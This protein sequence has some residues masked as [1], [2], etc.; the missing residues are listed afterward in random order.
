ME[1]RTYP[2][3][4]TVELGDFTEDD[5][6]RLA[7]QSKDERKMFSICDEAVVSIELKEGQA[8][9]T[10]FYEELR[11]LAYMDDRNSKEARSLIQNSYI[12]LYATFVRLLRNMMKTGNTSRA[13]QVQA[14]KMIAYIGDQ[15]AQA[16]EGKIRLYPS[17]LGS[18]NN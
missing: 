2:I 11:K 7:A 14:L 6:E 5:L 12:K 16:K 10:F 3:L 1:K 9:S 15:Y 17:D 4:V 18:S 13:F 8:Y